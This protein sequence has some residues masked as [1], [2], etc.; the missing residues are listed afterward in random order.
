LAWI[1]N[2]GKLAKARNTDA[3]DIGYGHTPYS[4]DPRQ[5]EKQCVDVRPS[6]WKRIGYGKDD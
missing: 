2:R 1:A 3:G 6:R 4:L 5:E